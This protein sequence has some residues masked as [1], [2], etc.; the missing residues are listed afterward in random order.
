MV[1]TDVRSSVTD[2][3]AVVPH[4]VVRVDDSIST[5]AGDVRHGLKG[6]HHVRR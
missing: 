1:K 2:D 3:A 5:L 4:K 6:G